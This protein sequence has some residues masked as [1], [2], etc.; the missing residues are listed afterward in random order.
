M[1]VYHKRVKI[2]KEAFDEWYDKLSTDNK[3]LADYHTA[4]IMLDHEVDEDTARGYLACALV[5]KRNLVLCRDDYR[6][7][8]HDMRESGLRW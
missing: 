3:N 6:W 4:Q 5:A 1:L 2:A 7:G 8:R